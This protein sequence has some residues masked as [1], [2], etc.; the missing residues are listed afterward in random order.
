MPVVSSG[1]GVRRPAT[2]DHPISFES[3]PGLT[4]S[5]ARERSGFQETA[6]SQSIKGRWQGQA[7]TRKRLDYA[8][9]HR[10]GSWPG[11][12]SRIGGGLQH[13]GAPPHG[14]VNNRPAITG[15]HDLAECSL[16]LAAVMMRFNAGILSGQLQWRYAMA[17]CRSAPFHRLLAVTLL[18]LAAPGSATARTTYVIVPHPPPVT[19]QPKRVS[20]PQRPL[21]WP[22]PVARGRTPG[23][24]S[25]AA[26]CYAG[27]ISCPLSQPHLVG[28]PCQC[29]TD[30]GRVAGRA[31]IPPSYTPGR[32][33]G[34][35][36]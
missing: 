19:P 31:L 2:R 22:L 29:N 6:A 8:S 4:R 34:S 24:P 9:Q 14:A 23:R 26:R 13:R 1:T 11:P 16:V 7:V 17:K 33:N 3:W 35:A 18:L 25:P 30:Q 28:K 5:A 10:A 20:P 36:R 15:R 27:P 32:R 21:Q 12:A